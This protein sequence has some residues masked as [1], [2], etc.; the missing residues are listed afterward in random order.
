MKKILILGATHNEG[1][2][3]ERARKKG[4]YTIVTDNHEDW[5]FSPAK[6]IADEA[7][8][9][10]W[11]DVES[12]YNKCLLYN[13]NGVIAGF[14]EFRVENMIKLCG[15]LSLPC[16]LTLE[17]LAVTRNKISFKRLCKQYN[18]TVVPEYTI[19][20]NV[21][22]P[23]IIKPVDRAGSIGVNVAYNDEELMTF[24]QN[25]LLLSPS[26]QAIIEDFIEDGIKFDVYY[27]IQYGKPILIG[28][29]DTI[30]YG[31]KCKILQKAWTFP[32]VYENLFLCEYDC[33]VK[34]MLDGLGIQNGYATLSAFYVK[35]SLCFFEAGFRL[36][37][38]L[39][40]NYYQAIT[41]INYLDFMIDCALGQNV[42]RMKQLPIDRGYSIILNFFGKDGTVGYI[43]DIDKILA[44]DCVI[45]FRLYIKEGTV[46]KNDSS[47]ILKKIGMCTIYSTDR[48][49]IDNIVQYV[50]DLFV[51]QN[52]NG[53]SLVY[54]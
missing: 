33:R 19:G 49:R 51:V 18:I 27:L 37:G 38:E 14:S 43:S 21:K 22:Y 7:W 23:V 47:S 3:V 42:I 15:K 26:R 29:S 12:L 36:S 30:M 54:K 2:I 16:Y 39:S 25:A 13:I 35:N 34:R 17:Q 48:T 40:F 9:I 44:I 50:N 8:N 1:L 5:S 4:I 11:S 6:Y 32:S 45:S 53:E 41:G 46:I 20:D 52:I 10:S 24:Y 31:G 28:T